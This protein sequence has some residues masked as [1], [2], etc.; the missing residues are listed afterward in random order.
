M[1]T[2]TSLGVVVNVGNTGKGGRERKESGG[3]GK[4]TGTKDAPL[5]CTTKYIH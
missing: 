5:E 4:G 2:N 3:E 1:N